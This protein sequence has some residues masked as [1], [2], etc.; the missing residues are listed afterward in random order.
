MSS[1]NKTE[2]QDDGGTV[3][4]QIDDVNERHTLVKQQS[5][6]V[7]MEKPTKEGGLAY[8]DEKSPTPAKAKKEDKIG[9]VY[10]DHG[11]GQGKSAPIT[12]EL[13]SAKQPAPPPKP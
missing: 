10:A 13:A 6:G 9:K 1:A 2:P 7:V 5:S 11:A 3:R 4:T 8:L 12:S